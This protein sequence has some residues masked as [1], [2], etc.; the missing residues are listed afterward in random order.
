M[1]K[2]TL[3]FF[4]F[5]FSAFVFSCKKENMGDCF[6]STGKISTE[7]RTATPFDTI[8]SYDNVNVF[9]INDTFFD[10]KVEAGENLIPLI[11]TEIKNN[12]LFIRNNNKCNWVRSFSTP[13][14]VY[15]TSPAPGAVYNEGTGNIKSL[16]TISGR[17]L[18]I[19]MTN[20]GDV[21]LQL[22]IP[23]L[24]VN[25]SAANGNLYLSGKTPLS[26]IFCIGTTLV[27]A[28]N[29]ET[30]RTFITTFGTGDM[31][32]SASQDVGANIHWIG[33]I[34]Y[35]GNASI[36]YANY[37]SSGRLVKK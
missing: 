2:I 19:K 37:H 8:A 36:L 29:F 18:I 17:T 13:I 35:S 25:I 16:N 27:F 24:M 5:L 20:S 14:N 22:D 4:S 28:E 6:K 31:H 7:H 26:E 33:N 10:I 12:T 32:V 3:Y 30:E 15:V 1:K 21:D 23:H 11:E 34:Y 9:L